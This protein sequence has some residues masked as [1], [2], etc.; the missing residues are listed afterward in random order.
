MPRKR[1]RAAADGDGDGDKNGE[2][3]EYEAMFYQS[4]V[5]GARSAD[6]NLEAAFWALEIKI[7]ETEIQRWAA[8]CWGSMARTA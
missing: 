4:G 5:L 6:Q 8:Q 1:T 3:E 7:F 2:E